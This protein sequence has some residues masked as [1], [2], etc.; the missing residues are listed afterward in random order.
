MKFA[1]IAIT[2]LLAIISIGTVSAEQDVRL[3]QQA[4]ADLEQFGTEK[5]LPPTPLPL[6]PGTPT[7]SPSP[8]GGSTT[9]ATTAPPTENTP[10]PVRW[11]DCCIIYLSVCWWA[12]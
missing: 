10:G 6:R 9:T 5:T 2:A 3:L 7:G 4:E 11:F 8:T 12:G 1:T